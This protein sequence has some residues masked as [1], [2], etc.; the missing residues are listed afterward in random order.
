MRDNE[1]LGLTKDVQ[2]VVS[3]QVGTV[4]REEAEAVFLEEQARLV[5][6]ADLK[7]RRKEVLY[8]NDYG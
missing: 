5:I 4:L 7:T 6:E 8:V 2:D 1:I 3:P